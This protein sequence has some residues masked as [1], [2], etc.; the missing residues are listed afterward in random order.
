MENYELHNQQRRKDC[1]EYYKDFID[2]MILGK[3]KCIRFRKWFRGYLLNGATILFNTKID[4]YEYI[5]KFGRGAWDEQRLRKTFNEK[6]LDTIVE[7]A[8]K[9]GAFDY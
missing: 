2:N 9:Y 6:E 8:E 5:N 1:I 7:L 3:Q 4:E